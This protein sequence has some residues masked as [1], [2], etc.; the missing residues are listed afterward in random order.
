MGDSLQLQNLV[1]L[2]AGG[3]A[4]RTIYICVRPW[5]NSAFNSPP[6]LRRPPVQHLQLHRRAVI[7]VIQ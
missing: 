1:S 5:L 2:P 3:C 6:R 4:P 7:V